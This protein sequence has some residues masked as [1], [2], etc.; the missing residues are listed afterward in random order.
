MRTK[1]VSVGRR[2]S[3]TSSVTP[4][5][6]PIPLLSTVQD[7]HNATVYDSDSTGDHTHAAPLPNF[8]PDSEPPDSFDDNICITC[9]RAGGPLLVCTQTDCPV[10]VHVTCIGSE[11][12]FDDSGNFFCPYC[13]Y[14]R[15]LK[16]T[17]ELREKAILAKKALSSFLEKSQTVR[18]DDDEE[19]EHIAEPEPVQPV[20]V[21]DEPNHNE[22]EP[23]QVEPNRN[24]PEPVQPV[25]D[26]QDV[27]D[28]E[29]RRELNSNEND[30]VEDKGKVSVSGSSVSEAK[31]SDSNSVS[32]KKGHV[33]ANAKGKRKVAYVKKSLLPERKTGGAGGGSGGG[34]GVDEEEV[35]SSRTFS[36]QKQVSKQNLITGKRRRLLWTDE[37]EKAL[38]EGVLK[39]STEKQNI[40]WRKILEFGCRVF[41]KTR[42]PVDLKDK[43]KNII[44]KEGKITKL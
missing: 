43:W 25:Q 14:K 23:V 17:R 5:A 16:R 6:S 27:S 3:I 2:R 36:V 28:S 41:D 9:N 24:E 11:P 19:E 44:S 38:K 7:N 10:V 13:S 8:V 26:E 37:E 30:K 18:K 22:P 15:A 4:S 35:T 42:T 39:Y 40:P 12:K 1:S 20:Q 32:V 33:N 31:N 29:E 34:D 21:Q